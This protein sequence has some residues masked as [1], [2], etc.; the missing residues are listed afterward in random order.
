MN[1][2]ERRQRHKTGKKKKNDDGDDDGDAKSSSTTTTDEWREEKCFFFFLLHNSPFSSIAM[3]SQA[4]EPCLPCLVC[5]WLCLPLSA[6]Q[7]IALTSA[8]ELK[9]SEVRLTCDLRAKKKKKNFS[10]FSLF[11]FLSLA[12]SNARIFP[13]G[14]LLPLFYYCEWAYTNTTATTYI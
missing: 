2:I 9:W 12:Q 7:V 13:I 3:L 8:W 5:L 6:K 14:P 1:R 4:C 11:L 10:F